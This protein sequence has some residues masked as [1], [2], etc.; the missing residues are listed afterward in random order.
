M[1]V[2]VALAVSVTK[3]VAVVLADAVELLVGTG[4]KEVREVTVKVASALGLKETVAVALGMA[5]R[6]TESAPVAVLVRDPPTCKEGEALPV[7]QLLRVRRL[8]RDSVGEKLTV[9]VP[10]LMG[11]DEPVALM[12]AVMEGEALTVPVAV[13][14]L[15][16]G[17]T[18]EVGEP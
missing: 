13:L 1:S 5:D 11:V 17:E 4:V 16:V 15:G 7:A 8:V 12:H 14:L 3:G 2:A 9:A 10:V 6:V 18:V